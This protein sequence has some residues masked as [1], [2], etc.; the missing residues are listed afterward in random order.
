MFKAHS[1]GISPRIRKDFRLSAKCCNPTLVLSGA[2]I[3]TSILLKETQTVKC[4]VCLSWQ[5][6]PTVGD[7]W[8][9]GALGSDYSFRC[10]LPSVVWGVKA[11]GFF[12]SNKRNCSWQDVQQN[13]EMILGQQGHPC[14]PCQQVR[15]RMSIR[16]CAGHWAMC[17]PHITLS[18][19]HFLLAWGGQWH[20]HKQLL[21]EFPLCCSYSMT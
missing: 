18:E 12:S 2:A 15:K 16:H 3:L 14:T 6:R 10:G 17:L 4:L 7:I 9:E 5:G 20:L 11:L 8:G 13:R 21:V 19:P 1:S